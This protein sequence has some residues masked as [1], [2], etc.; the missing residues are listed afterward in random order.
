MD[1][2][3]ARRS[4]REL[5]GAGGQWTRVREG[6]GETEKRCFVRLCRGWGVVFLVPCILTEARFQ[7]WGGGWGGGGGGEGGG[8]GKVF[9]F[10]WFCFLN[11]TASRFMPITLL[12]DAAKLLRRKISEPACRL[13]SRRTCLGTSIRAL[14]A[15]FP[16]CESSLAQR[17]QAFQCDDGTATNPQSTDTA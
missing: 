8:E 13:S 14:D 4:R 7:C 5:V 15:L 9:P 3:L 16:R 6:G 2:L 12:A 1:L 17:L 11:V 10:F